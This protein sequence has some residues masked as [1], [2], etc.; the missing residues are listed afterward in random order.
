MNSRI[1]LLTACAIW[2]CARPPASAA[3][4][5]SES[6]LMPNDTCTTTLAAGA[7]VQ[8]AIDDADAGA[9]LCLASGTYAGPLFID[10]A[11]TLRSATPSA[12]AR[13]DAAGKGPALVVEGSGRVTL[14]GL[15]LC[16][17]VEGEAGG[18]LRLGGGSDVVLRGVTLEQNRGGSAGGAAIYAHAAKLSLERCRVQG[19]RSERRA[20]VLLADSGAEVHIV[21]SLITD[22]HA[23]AGA[24]FE[25][26]AASTLKLSGTTVVANEAKA[27]FGLRPTT[28]SAP[29]LSVDASLLSHS[30][31]LVDA[32]TEAPAPAVKVEHS[33]LHG[34]GADALGASNR[35][36]APEFL[37]ADGDDRYRPKPGSDAFG[38]LDAR[39]SGWPA[40]DL[41]GRDRAAKPAVG[42]FD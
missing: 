38:L 21:G 37:G 42:A 19:N 3:A 34:G 7:D 6:R 33:L 36:S 15:V 13:V 30:G 22:N 28:S 2:A 32:P 20:A 11:L 23:G 14:D 8:A 26:D 39:P 10:K 4:P 24:L 40:T 1:V 5:R 35:Q 27:L 29:K 16:G 41:T 25:L 9:T 12:Q 31:A 17:G 18:G